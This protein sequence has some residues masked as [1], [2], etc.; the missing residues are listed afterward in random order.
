MV[1][2]VEAVLGDKMGPV[3]VPWAALEELK[4]REHAGEWDSCKSWRE[5]TPYKAGDA[6]SVMKGPFESFSGT[7][8]KIDAESRIW[9]LIGIFGRQTK[10]AMD[11]CQLRAAVI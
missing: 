11:P 2:D 5:K 3:R 8:D 4:R 6:V 7:V 9:I 10:I 1:D